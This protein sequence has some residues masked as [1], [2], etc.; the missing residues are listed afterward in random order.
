MAIF[1]INISVTLKHPDNRGIK[2]D[3][4]FAVNGKTATSAVWRSYAEM[5]RTLC[6]S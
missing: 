6:L 1:F 2:H 3:V 4:Y 5:S